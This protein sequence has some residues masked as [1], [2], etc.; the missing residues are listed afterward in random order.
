MT[1]LHT[2]VAAPATGFDPND[3]DVRR[4]PYPYYHWL[5]RHDPVHRGAKGVWY[6][7]RYPDVRAVLT[8]AR[9]GRA[10]IRDTWKELIGP[11]LLSRIVG[12]IILF[13]DEPDHGRLRDVVGPAFAPGALRGMRPRIAALVAGMLAEPAERGQL[14]VVAE[15]SY[16]LALTVVLDVLGLPIADRDEIGAW[17][18]AI[19]RTLDRGTGPPEIAAGHRAVAEFAEYVEELIRRRRGAPGTDLLG[20]ML[21]AHRR[22]RIS[23]NEIISTVVTFIFTGHETVS[24]QIGNSVLCL[25]RHPD[26]LRLLRAQPWRIDAAVEECLRYDPSIQSNSR[27]LGE[28]VEFRGRRMGEGDY[29]VVLVA[30]ANRDPGQFADPDRFDITRAQGPSL[31]FGAGMRYCLGSYLARLELRAAL[32]ALVRL[33]DL[34]LAVAPEQLAYQPGTMFRGLAALP[35]A[36]RPTRI[37]TMEVPA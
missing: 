6:V 36:Y 17:S 2:A 5:L 18:R 29:V 1:A 11:G 13:Q 30:A 4:D 19:G 21:A 12:D 34:H 3:R 22:G 9:F 10:G 25:L 8:D 7:S 24:S 32:A 27:Q 31:S 20:T 26:Q 23:M 35:V 14:D 28:E 37:S 16:P 33:P 15:L